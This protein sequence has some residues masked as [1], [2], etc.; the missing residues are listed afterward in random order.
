MPKPTSRRE[1]GF[2]LAELLVVIAVLAI[3]TALVVFAVGGITDRGEQAACE[4]T[5]DSIRTASD[6]YTALNGEPAS[7]LAVL[8]NDEL[9]TVDDDVSVSGNVAALD[10]GTVTYHAGE[11]TNTCAN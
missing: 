10:G 4:A 8:V 9:L 6:A 11:V 1:H 7:S 3:L 2:T 5:A